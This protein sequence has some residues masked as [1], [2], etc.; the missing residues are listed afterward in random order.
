MTWY[1]GGTWSVVVTSLAVAAVSGF[2]LLHRY[3][4]FSDNASRE[5]DGLSRQLSSWQD[6]FESLH[7]QSRQNAL[8]LSQMSDGVVVIAQDWTVLLM[9]PPSK[10]LLGL[11]QDDHHLG[12]DLRA[13]ARIPGLVAA[14]E[15]VRDGGE[16]KR[17]N[18]E[19]SALGKVRPV[20]VSV[21]LIE[22]KTG[23][24]LLLT[25]HDETEAKHLEAV[26]REFIA[27]VSHELKTPLAAI[28]GYAETVELA[29]QDDPAAATHFMSQIR[30]QC[31]RLER[32]VAGMMQLARAQAGSEKLH[33][34][35][36]LLA[37]VVGESMETYGPVANAKQITLSPGDI[38]RAAKAFVD[39][40]ATLTIANNLIGNA[41]RYTPEGGSVT[42]HVSTD[43]QTS[44]LSVQDD[45]VGIEKSELDRIFERFYRVE[46]TRESAISGTGLGLSIVR[47]LTSSLAG[48]ILVDSV[49][50]RG[51]T[52]TVVLPASE[53]AATAKSAQKAL[54][55]GKNEQ[56]AADPEHGLRF[57]AS[58]A[59][60]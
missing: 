31:L 42:I 21:R 41:I 60:G 16:S 25:I 33:L 43:G 14:I 49:P 6:R 51:S 39:R 47:N 23:G 38:D 26:R 53:D 8:V 15:S 48:G 11:R 1:A 35:S 12:A 56:N 28:K 7:V 59:S 52:F 20:S 4:V 46:K 58:G 40:E 37:D 36:V 22:A 50:G 2:G 30:D 44:R 13:I 55:V 27:N 10:E 24:N 9:N 34:S 45:G 19:I 29:I 3:H 18:M 32:L 5:I 54:K 17:V 57:Q